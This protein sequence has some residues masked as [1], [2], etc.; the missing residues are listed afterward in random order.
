MIGAAGEGFSAMSRSLPRVAGRAAGAGLGSQLGSLGTSSGSRSVRP[1]ESGISGG[2]TRAYHSTPSTSTSKKTTGRGSSHRAHESSDRRSEETPRSQSTSSTRRGILGAADETYRQYKSQ[3]AKFQ[4]FR[5]DWRE[6]IRK[7]LAGA[8]AMETPLV[9]GPLAKEK[10]LSEA[11]QKIAKAIATETTAPRKEEE[12]ELTLAQGLKIVGTE[13]QS[14][15]DAA[16]EELD[17]AFKKL[18]NEKEET[19]NRLIEEQEKLAELEDGSEETSEKLDQASTE[20]N[21]MIQQEELELDILR[22]QHELAKFML[23]RESALHGSVS[24]EHLDTAMA[25]ISQALTALEEISGSVSQASVAK[26]FFDLTSTITS[27]VNSSIKGARK[28]N[29]EEIP[30]LLPATQET[31]QLSSADILKNMM[32]RGADSALRSYASAEFDHYSKEVVDKV[33]KPLEDIVCPGSGF[34]LHTAKEMIKQSVSS[35]KPSA[36]KEPKGVTE[37]ELRKTVEQ[38]IASY[39]KSEVT[40]TLSAATGKKITSDLTTHLKAMKSASSLQASSRQKKATE[41]VASLQEEY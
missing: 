21:R 4:D 24:I 15:F 9:K 23:K 34:I 27:V 8:F 1:M 7:D 6:G 33:L 25:R 28:L 36:Y 38:P 11:G 29:K 22:S 31:A 40:T 26:R 19:I 41:L 20:L 2:T 35:L 12:P 18:E 10:E 13:L 30:S 37:D 5:K 16:R 14:Q 39:V 32:K 17:T 3:W